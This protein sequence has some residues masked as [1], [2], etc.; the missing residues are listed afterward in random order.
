MSL[1]DKDRKIIKIIMAKYNG[2]G[3]KMESILLISDR[4][5]NDGK[6]KNL[7]EVNTETISDLKKVQLQFF[8]GK[9]SFN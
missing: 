1:V 8:Y 2:E 4:E 3:K 9:L 6:H 5:E 7:E